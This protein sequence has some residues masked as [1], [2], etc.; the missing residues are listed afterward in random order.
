MILAKQR[1]ARGPAWGLTPTGLVEEVEG[2]FNIPSEGF[3]DVGSSVFDTNLVAV[4]TTLDRSWG[5][6][7]GEL[8]PK[9]PQVDLQFRR[10]KR[11]AS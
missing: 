2:G 9:E 8:A 5:R 11:S 7:V 10:E 1:G 4:S 3:S 6:R